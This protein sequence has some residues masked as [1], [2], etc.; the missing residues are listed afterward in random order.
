MI[1]PESV[2]YRP[3]T[4]TGLIAETNRGQR[5]NA[6]LLSTLAALAIGLAAV[7]L[8]KGRSIDCAA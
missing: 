2:L 8:Y 6:F 4:L 3:N 5:F 1:D 7:G